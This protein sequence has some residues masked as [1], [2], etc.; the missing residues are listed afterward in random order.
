MQYDTTDPTELIELNWAKQP[1]GAAG[2]GNA[3]SAVSGL[4]GSV[5]W[6][7]KSGKTRRTGVQT[8]YEKGLVHVYA[9]TM[10]KNDFVKTAV[11]LCIGFRKLIRWH[12]A[13]AHQSR[14]LFDAYSAGNVVFFVSSPEQPPQALVSAMATRNFLPVQF[15]LFYGDRSDV[16]DTDDMINNLKPYTP[17]LMD[18]HEVSKWARVPSEDHIRLNTKFVSNLKAELSKVSFE[19]LKKWQFEATIPGCGFFEDKFVVHYDGKGFVE[20][21][22]LR[23]VIGDPTKDNLEEAMFREDVKKNAGKREKLSDKMRRLRVHH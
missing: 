18:K 4:E 11:S 12:P 14:L 10:D 3:V 20:A 21:T 23:P 7:E 15:L 2:A 6:I 22:T 19:D 9:I 1:G 8:N 5:S 16:S 17:S 13:R